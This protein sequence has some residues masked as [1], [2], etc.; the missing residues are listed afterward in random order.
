M[1]SLIAFAALAIAACQSPPA[2]VTSTIPPPPEG[3]TPSPAEVIAASQPAEW[4]ALDPENTLYMDFPEGRVVI[5]MAPQFAPSH[6]ANV[7]A[8]SREGFFANGAVTRVQDNFVTQW[9]Q[10]ADP[11]RPPKVGVEKLNA[12]F[13]LPRVAIANFDVLPDPDTYADEVGYINGMTAARDAASVWLT[14]C[15]GMVGVGRENDENSGGGTEL[16]VIIGHSPRNLDRQL[17]MLGRVVQGMEIM[18]AFPRGTGDAGFYKTPAEYRRYADIKV[19]A[20]VPVAQRTNLEVM[21][22]DSAS[23][24][25]LVNSRRWRKDDFYTKP[26]GRIGLCNITVPVRPVN[27]AS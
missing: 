16:Y 12:E 18:S 10:A 24:A 13:T 22:T 1:R 6:V 23:F 14:H 3:N 19:A 5:E 26:V 2:T 27:P 8:L 21:R 4:R 15:Y 17:T 25:T 9:A 7:K 20:D 11:A